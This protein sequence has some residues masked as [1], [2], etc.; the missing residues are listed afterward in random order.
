MRNWLRAILLIVSCIFFYTQRT[1][2]NNEWIN[3]IDIFIERAIHEHED[4]NGWKT[5]LNYDL[6][7]I[8]I[9]GNW[10]TEH[11]ITANGQWY[12]LDIR[13]NLSSSCKFSWVPIAIEVAERKGWYE[14]VS[15]RKGNWSNLENEIREKFSENAYKNRKMREYSNIEWKFDALSLAE[16]F[17]KRK[18]D[19]NNDFECKFCDKKRYFY[20]TIQNKNWEYENLYGTEASDKKY[21]VFHTGWILERDSTDTSKYS[22]NFWKDDLTIIIK[23]KTNT[24]AIERFVITDL[25]DDKISFLAEKIDI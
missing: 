16:D 11:Y 22:R 24:W 6:L 23:D 1:S 7:G 5:F 12:F 3:N 8:S 13:G 20:D 15:Y 4:C 2:T 9:K 19:E 10:N 14:L 21:F 17:F 25:R 18:L